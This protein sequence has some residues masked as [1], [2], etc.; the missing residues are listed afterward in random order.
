MSKERQNIFL[1]DGHALCYRAYYAIRELSTSSGM[2]T[3]AIYGF[4]NILRKLIKE[5]KPGMLAIVFDMAAPTARHEKYKEYKIHRKPMP[6]DLIDQ[7]PKIKDVIAAYRIP[8]C[9]MEGYE[10]DDIIAT[11]AEKAEK[12]GLDVT[13][14]TGDK[15][16]LQLVDK[17]I[18]V[19][20]PSTSGDKMYGAAEVRSKYGVDPGSMVDLMALTGDASDNI[21]GVK[22]IGQVTASKL[23]DQYGSVEGVYRNINEISSETLRKKLI[24]GEAMARLSRELVQLERE[25]PVKLDF[26]KATRA[27]PDLK[28]LSEL[29]KKFEFVRLLREVTPREVKKGKYSVIS[30]EKEI[31]EITDRIAKCKTVSMSVI[32]GSSGKQLKAVAFSLKEGE[33][34]F[35]PLEDEKAR[36]R[37]I[38]RFVKEILED[39]KIK[40]IGYDIK[41]DMPI[42]RDR[43]IALRGIA[44]DVMMADYLV[45]PSRSRYGLSDIAMRQMGYNLSDDKDSFEFMRACERSDVILR[46]YNVL[47]PMLEERHLASLFRDVEMPLISVLA[48]M[49]DKG[50]RIDVKYLEERSSAMEKKLADVS[51]KI[52]K[53]AGE[54]FNINSPKQLQV[55]L[56]DKL[57]LPVTKKTKTGIS[58]DES[59]LRKLAAIHELPARLL[60]YREMNKLKTGYYDS[61]VDLA[62]KKTGELHARFNQAVTATGRLSSSE[63]N[64]Q[65]IPIRTKLGKEIRRAFVSGEKGKLLLA[66]DYS[67]VELRILAHMSKDK[68]LIKAF[69]E[70]QDVHR[71]TAS[72]IFDC[73]IGEVTDEMRSTA[74]TVNFGIIYGM[75]PF[76]LSKDLGIGIEEA[77]KFI[78]SYFSRYSGVKAFIDRTIAGARKTGFVATLLK[79]RRYLP[80]INSANENVKSFAERAAVNTPVQ[81]SAADIIKLAM[82]NCDSKF[83]DSEV[84]MIIQVH[85]ELVF[86]VPKNILKDTAEQ[87]RELMEG[88]VEL[89]VPLKVDIEA[90]ENWLDM[91]PVEPDRK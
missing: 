45:D 85:D 34:C 33:G 49:E 3:N 82:I 23:I 72:L 79:R 12:K 89:E 1:I 51:G 40:K 47:D 35:F 54:E 36:S 6:D 27:E 4:I 61:I 60:E 48:D 37:G 74:K 20:N 87:V 91:E 71:F 76:G 77:R 78:D 5:H 2:P 86:E 66:A 75:S 50:V 58:T 90:G 44:F 64:L 28:R 46:L 39:E 73:P 32:N 55:I 69:K 10:A 31:K 88:A 9:Q 19:L 56:Y 7:I 14:V 81:G 62:D 67:Q 22:G 52:Y 65:N 17:K 59:V 53:L 11:L 68:K 57:A 16:A 26:D 13:I 29:Y 42:L 30:G 63:P 80:E 70:G 8:V 15:D 41:K 38:T 83:R 18:R 84:R 43:G 21:P 24:E 25:V